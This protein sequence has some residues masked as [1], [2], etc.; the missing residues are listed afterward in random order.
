MNIIFRRTESDGQVHNYQI[1]ANAMI[2]LGVNITNA[3][4]QTAEYVAKTNL[5]DI[6]NPL[7][8]ISLGGGNYLYVKMIDN[9]E[10]GVNDSISFVLVEGNTDPTVL[11]NVLYASNWVGSISRMMNLTGGNLVVKSGFSVTP[12]IRIEGSTPATPI[13]VAPAIS[14]QFNVKVLGNPTLTS[15]RL[16]LQ[17][18]NMQEKFTVKVVDVNGRLIEVQ[19]NLYAGQVIELGSK[20]TQGTYFA[21]VTQGTNR[22]LVKLVKI[23]RD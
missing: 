3:K 4:R 18:S 14:E 13:T 23:S 7:S 8:P 2:S 21:E 12:A 20:Y 10:P 22:K 5:T 6:T 9:G 11:S 15:F 19:Q 16:Q 1:K 17:S